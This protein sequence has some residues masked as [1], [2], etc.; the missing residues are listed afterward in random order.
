[1][2][3]YGYILRPDLITPTQAGETLK[4]ALA[5]PNSQARLL[6]NLEVDSPR[7]R[8]CITSQGTISH[9][10]GQESIIVSGV[11]AYALDYHGGLIR[12]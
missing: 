5:H 10:S 3:Y 7:G 1:M 11:T 4:A 8:F 12:P 9:F 2:N 6:D